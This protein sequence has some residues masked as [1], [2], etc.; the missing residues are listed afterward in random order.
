MLWPEF[1]GFWDP[2]RDFEDMRRALRRLAAPATVEFPPVNVWAKED[3]AVV[4]TEIPGIEK[5]SLDISVEGHTLTLRGSRKPLELKEGEAYHRR[6]R[7]HNSF[8]KTIE[9]PFNVEAGKVDARYSRGVLYINL[10]RAEAERPR[11]I[12][13]TSE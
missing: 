13:I 6:E 1:D 2:W 5:E 12:A 8:S 11:K 7:W 10:P 9:L 3:G 4:T